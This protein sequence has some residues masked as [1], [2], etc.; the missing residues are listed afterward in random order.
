[1]SLRSFS[2]AARSPEP[3]QGEVNFKRLSHRG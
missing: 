1:M 3:A 2:I